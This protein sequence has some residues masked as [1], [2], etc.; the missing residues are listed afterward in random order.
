MSSVYLLT[1]EAIIVVDAVH[2]GFWRRGK[3]SRDVPPM[4][5]CRLR[6][7]VLCRVDVKE[8]PLSFKIAN[9]FP[10]LSLSLSACPS[11]GL[12]VWPVCPWVCTPAL[13][14]RLFGKTDRD[15]GRPKNAELWLATGK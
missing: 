2:S 1:Q 15:L 9:Y 13:S 11:P 14:L 4:C 6:V 12:S 5:Q 8:S 10:S 3:I 7:Y